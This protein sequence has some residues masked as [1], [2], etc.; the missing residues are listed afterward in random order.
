MIVPLILIGSPEST[1]G[2]NRALRAALSAEAL[3]NGWP[4]TASADTTEPFSS[5]STRTLTW[6]RA[7]TALAAD[8]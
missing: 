8:G 7:L 3:S 1:V 4:E 5:I 6:P 2:E